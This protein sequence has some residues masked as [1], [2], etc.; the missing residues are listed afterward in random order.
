MSLPTLVS[1]PD[2][3]TNTAYY[4]RLREAASV[5]RVQLPNGFPIWLV[6]RYDDVRACLRD[7]RLAVDP[8]LLSSPEHK[9]GGR[10]VPEDT[11]SSTGRH[12]LNT[13]G[14]EHR[15]LR[16]LVNA[17]LSSGAVGR[18]RATV[19]RIVHE[20]L[21]HLE[22]Q[23]AAAGGGPVNLMTAFANQV[24]VTVISTVLGLRPADTPVAAALLRELLSSKP[25]DSPEMIGYYHE[26]VDLVL[27]TVEHRR[28]DPGDDLISMLLARSESVGVR[29]L[30]STVMALFVGGP[31]TTATA[32]AHGA[33]TLGARPDLRAEALGSEAS[34]ARIVEEL[35]RHH[36][37]FQFAIWRFATADVR[38]G[39]VVIPKDATVLL[40]LAAAN[41]DPRVYDDPDV[42]R[43]HRDGEP[44]HL[45]FGSGV[46]RCIGAP[47]A[48]MEITV[49][50]RS[51]F[52]RFPR[53]R[54]AVDP[55][56]LCWSDMV[57]DRRLES[58]PVDLGGVRA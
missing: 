20:Q 6:T 56:E 58:M 49:A 21:D 44:S 47:L 1:L 39:D 27:A 45:S 38:V 34:T 52:L 57:F 11:L 55:H 42:V 17:E 30:L 4:A 48:R 29:D 14:A 25:T 19:D 36:P 8:R 15:R 33:A 24:P 43:S 13:D 35:L 22:H 26:L 40:S 31:P 32:I 2:D 53:L 50:V 37:P 41:R 5:Q 10:R 23:G 7:E 16:S 54:L 51:L 12:M 9:F 18:W 3:D 46:H 28:N